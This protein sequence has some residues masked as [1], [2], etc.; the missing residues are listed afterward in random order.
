M[1]A[2]RIYVARPKSTYNTTYGDRHVAF[3]RKSY[4]SHEVVDPAGLYASFTD[5][6]RRWPAIA[7]TLEA[8]VLVTNPDGTVGYG[9]YVEYETART[10]GIPIRLLTLERVFI[11]RFYL[12]KLCYGVDLRRYARAVVRP[13]I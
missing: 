11:E 8:F 10:L 3:V 9:C 7:A 1:T 4:R 5:F 13:P 12:H 2:P 6:E